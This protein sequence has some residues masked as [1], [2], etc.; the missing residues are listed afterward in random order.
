MADGFEH[1]DVT[2]I[3]LAADEEPDGAGPH[4]IVLQALSGEYRIVVKTG[5][6]V[7]MAPPPH[8][9]GVERAAIARDAALTAA[10]RLARARGLPSIYL[11]EDNSTG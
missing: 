4:I 5:E 2:L 11:R 10:R 6:A 8:Q 3:S 9:P 7:E 1:K